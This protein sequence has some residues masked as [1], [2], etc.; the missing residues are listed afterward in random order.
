MSEAFAIKKKNMRTDLSIYNNNWYQPGPAW[1]RATWFI[2]NMLFFKHSLFPFYAPKR[3]MLRLFGA[4]VGKRLIIKDA[5][6]IKY[7]WF[8]SIGDDC[9]FGEGVWIDNLAMVTI[10]N[11]VCLSQGAMLLSGNHDYSKP[12]FDLILKPIV[13]EDGVWIG[14]KAMVCS[15][16]TCGSHAVLAVQS[17]ANKDL[18]P[19]QIYRGNPCEK[20]KERKFI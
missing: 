20:V 4:K 11:N 7:P 14:A 6:N 3:A 19:W 10:G 9:W 17:V 5:V 1:K 2:V 16:V 18:E 12:T 8:L 13:L 15:G